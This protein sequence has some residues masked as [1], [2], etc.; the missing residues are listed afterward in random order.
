MK[1]IQDLEDIEGDKKVKVENAKLRGTTLTW[2]TSLQNERVARGLDKISNRDRMK[3]MV[4]S[5]FLQSDLAIQIKMRRNNLNQRDMDVMS[6]T[7]KF[8]TL[9]I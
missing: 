6:Y 4:R 2:W 9:S 7:E 3:T 5:R 1:T 8:H